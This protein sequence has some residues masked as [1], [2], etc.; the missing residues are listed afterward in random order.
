MG[1]KQLDFRKRCQIYGLWKSGHN[2]T[3]I[4]KEIGGPKSTISREFKR[5]TCLRRR[6]QWGNWEYKTHYAQ[7]YA[8]ERHKNK[9]KR[10]KFTKAV[11]KFVDE[12][13][14]GFATPNEIFYK[15]ATY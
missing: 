6:A 7:T 2:Q 5:N 3:E 8:D 10:I 4:A 15:N 1:Y 12:K 11:E 9:P 13:A 14:L